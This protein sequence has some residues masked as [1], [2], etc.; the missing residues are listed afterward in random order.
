MSK[1]EE[2]KQSILRHAVKV[3]STDGLSGLTIG[4]L[5]EDLQL[6]KSGLFAHFKSKEQ[7][8][9][10]TVRAATDL[11]V[12]EVITPALKAPRGEARCLALV[13][14]WLKWGR[15]KGGCFFMA[16]A[17]ELDDKPGPVRDAVSQ[18]FSD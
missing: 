12:T 11:F 18:A 2:T 13:Q 5:A 3:A 7:L 6:S 4:R 10:D 17:A 14:E 8:Q 1:G 16:A 9:I 15:R